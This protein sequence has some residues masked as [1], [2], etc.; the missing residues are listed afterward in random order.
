MSAG[1][2]TLRTARNAALLAVAEV[3]GKAGSLVYVVLAARALGRD[4]F[5]AFSYAVA[6]SLLL[7]SV[8]AWGFDEFL[9]QRASSDP[10]RRESLARTAVTGKLLLALPT[11]GLVGVL[12]SSG[13]PSAAATTTLVLVFVAA[14]ADLLSDTARAVAT[15]HERLG[16]VSVALVVNRVLTAGVAVVAIVLGGGLVTIA[17]AYLVGS[18][19]GLAVS[20]VVVGRLGTRLVPGGSVADVLAVGRSAW[21]IG[22][23]TVFGLV[24]FR[25][26]TVLLEAITNDEEVARYTVAYRLVETVLFVSWSV[27]RAVLP[28]LARDRDPLRSRQV[29][30]GASG[31]IAAVY[32]PFALVALFAARPTIALLFGPQYGDTAVAS[33]QLLAPAPLLFAFGYVLDRVLMARGAFRTSMVVVVGAA[34]LNVL[35]NVVWIPTHGARGAAVATGV[36][37]GVQ[38]LVTLLV[39]RG[40]GTVVNPLRQ[41]VVPVV[42]GVPMAGVFLG[43]G[44]RLHVVVAVAIAGLVYAVGWGALAARLAP[45]QAELVRGLVPWRRLSRRAP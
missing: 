30:E 9:I 38:G 39:L 27:G 17:S 3:V 19:S 5:G 35:L 15:V 14:V 42:A 40:R 21:A 2:D 11:F 20:A 43:L 36:S 44:D 23:T 24:L 33:L 18:L 22:I 6:L 7:S 10:E 41:W 37:Y 12:V 32:V 28:V 26:D 16:G 31:A 34:A 45:T 29:V 1:D 13:R 25:I 8:A 4:E